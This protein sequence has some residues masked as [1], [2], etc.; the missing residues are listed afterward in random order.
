MYSGFYLTQLIL[1]FYTMGGLKIKTLMLANASF[2]I[3]IKAFFNAFRRREQA[4]DATNTVSY[5]SPFNYVR[6]QVY[7][8]IF[9]LLTTFV[10]IVKALY[11]DEFSI[12]LAW[13][14]INTVVFG[15]FVWIAQQE[16]RLLRRQRRQM[17][18]LAKQEI[19]INKG[20]TS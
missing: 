8:Y 4:W 11:T 2:P 15:Y 20:A 18:K 17:K 9:L 1:A 3:Y 5:D 13:N 12:S 16:A 19:L 14:A 6:M 7:V 10:G